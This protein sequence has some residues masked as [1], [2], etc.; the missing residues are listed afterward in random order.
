MHVKLSHI[1]T[2]QSLNAKQ[3]VS[4]HWSMLADVEVGVTFAMSSDGRAT[5]P[6]AA[7]HGAVCSTHPVVTIHCLRS[8]IRSG[9]LRRSNITAIM[10]FK[11][12]DFGTNRKPICDFLPPILHR[13]QDTAHYWSNFR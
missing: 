5:S 10:P 13:F 11:V 4:L 2:Y 9:E 12:T 6:T 8:V 3:F 7:C 1:I